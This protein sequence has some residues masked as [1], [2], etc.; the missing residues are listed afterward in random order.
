MVTWLLRSLLKMRLNATR[1]GSIASSRSFG[2]QLDDLAGQ[3]P[4]LDLNFAQNKSLIDDYSGTTLVTFTRASS[5]TYVDSQGVIRT[6]VTNLLLRSEE[7]DNASWGGG[8]S[9]NATVTPNAIAA[10]FGSITAD[11]LDDTSTTQVQARSQVIN[12]VSSTGSYTL[13][14][15]VRPNTSSIVSLRLGLGGAT[16]TNGEVVVDLA[17]GA[18]QW[19]SG[20]NVGTSFAITSAGG[21]WYRISVTVTDNGTG[22]NAATIE[23]RPAFAL[24]YTDTLN[25]TA[26]G[27]AYF[28][29]AQLEQS[30]TVGEY[31]PTTSTIN[32]APRFDHNPT[33]GESLGLL[34]EEA[35]TNVVTWSQ[36]FS[37]ADWTKNAST[38]VTTAV[39]SPIQGVNYQKIEATSANT[40]VGITSVAVTA[41]TQQRAVS[42]F[43]QPLGNISRV[44]VV[45]QGADARI[46]VNLADGTFT[47]NAAATGSTVA[48]SGQRFSVSTPTLTNATGVRLFLKQTGDTDTNTPTTIAIGEGLYFWGAQLEVGAFPTSYIPTVAATATR[49]ADVASITGSNFGVTRTN[50]LVRSEEFD[51]ASWAKVASSVT[52]NAVSS[53]DGTVTADKLIEAASSAWHYLT[54]PSIAIAAQTYVFSVFAK[55]A[56]RSVLQII[57][58]GAVF[59]VAYVNFDLT[60]GT[61]SASSGVDSAS[62]TAVGDGWYRCVLV[63]TA[64]SA[65]SVNAGYFTI[66]NSPTASRASSYTGDGTSGL[67]I[68][69]AQLE[70]GSA[71]TPYIQSPSV[72]TSRA[73]SGTYVGGNGLIQTATTN[74][75]RY[76]HDP[77]SLI[78]KGLLLE[79]ARTNLI[80]SS[81]D[82]AGFFTEQ[83]STA[84]ADAAAA[85]DGT[86]TADLLVPNTSPFSHT[87]F[88]TSIS[89]SASTTYSYSIFVKP[90]GYSWLQLLFTSGFNDPTAWVNFDL[91]GAGS[92]GFTGGGEI[93]KEIESHPGGWY[94]C[95][96]TAT[97]GAS[98]FAGGPAYLVLDSNRNGRDANYAGDN[99]SGVYLWGAQLEAGAFATSYIPTVA[100]TV[101]R[102]ADISTSV[103]TS[104]FESSF[105]NQ[106][107]GTVFTDCSITYTVPGSLFPLVSSLNDGTSNNRIE[108]GFLTSTLAG[109]EVVASGSAQ[110]G[111][112][113]SAVSVLARRL[114]TNYQLNNFAACVN[115]KS[116]STD[117]TGIVPTVSQLR[118][119]D[120]AGGASTNVLN[121]TI[122]RLTY[123]PTRLGNEVLQRITQ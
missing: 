26:Q 27:S 7:F 71:V 14:A 109:Y 31:I 6:A 68:W 65:A 22:N 98:P 62:I 48:V 63:D 83:N 39:A 103:A 82:I 52:A 15:F 102:A 60:A 12:I 85:P 32:S 3:V 104:V 37:Q 24:T 111:V 75:A 61:V 40:T 9:G 67:Y 108:N 13:S 112:Y 77:V 46:N 89:F 88:N 11:L 41:A 25:V 86:V 45:V 73:S 23:L 8:A 100:A 51:N 69:G 117:T 36:D 21:D 81:S 121:G 2:D 54:A 35:R 34:V 59:P 92:F 49:A 105:Y 94:R 91:T 17:T 120:R 80:T 110:V 44:L 123:W 38:V 70:V 58:N 84:T 114:A 119:G 74:E 97:S 116:I 90:N 30:A 96:I 64:T 78:S 101:T 10:P 106:T 122:K 43:A 42:F 72:F 55:A 56:E 99:T 95:T 87:S 28:W 47:T 118:I 1:L 53:P 5:G 107:E 50:L 66:Q 93:S 57:P 113:P 79:E 19:R 16:A 20:A 4:S 76:D 29:G 18:A 115:G 33:T